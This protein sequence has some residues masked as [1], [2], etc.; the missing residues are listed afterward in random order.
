DPSILILIEGHTD[1]TNTEDYNNILSQLRAEAVK[2]YLVNKGVPL[3]RIDTKGYGEYM[4]I[5]D[6]FTEEGK[7]LNRRVTFK[8]TRRG[9]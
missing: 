5:A 2:Q 6:N 3:V 9:N 1:N 7:I 8:I 4:P